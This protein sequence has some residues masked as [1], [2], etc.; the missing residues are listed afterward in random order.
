MP[1]REYTPRTGKSGPVYHVA[2][3]INVRMDKCGAWTLFFEKE[4]V[5]KNQKFGRDVRP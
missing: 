5:R 1:W 3:G 2:R 4:S